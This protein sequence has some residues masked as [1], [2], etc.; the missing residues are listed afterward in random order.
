MKTILVPTDF[1]SHAENAVRAAASIAS[2]NNARLILLHMA[3][4][5]D[6]LM[7]S[8][9]SNQALEAVFY[10]KKAEQQFAQL[11]KA[12]YLQGVEVTPVLKKHRNFYEIN[13]VAQEYDAQLIVMS[14]RG[15]N[16]L[17]EL[18]IGSNTEKVVRTADIP[19]LVVKQFIAQFDLDM[20][21]YASDFSLDSIPAFKKARKFF[22]QFNA[23]MNLVYVNTPNTDFKSSREIDLLI[24]NFFK[25]LGDPHPANR[26]ED[27]T[28]FSDYTVEQGVIAYSQMANADLIVVPTHGRKGWSHFLNG[29]IT[30]DIANHAVRPVLTIKI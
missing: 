25:E 30:E 28:V 7:T 18:M 13:E 17:H 19:V 21:V 22:G 3:G 27:V 2:K 10:Y 20:G 26:I 12:S 6:S 24:F 15:S 4:M 9:E 5:E 14:S 23:A 1:S 8:E 29:S 11:S 16:G